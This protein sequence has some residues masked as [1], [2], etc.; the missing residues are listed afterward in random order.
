MKH[1]LLNTFLYACFAAIFG[2]GCAA[3]AAAETYPS[4][5][6]K[7]VVPYPPGGPYDTIARIVG[8]KLS[9][10]LGQPFIVENRAGANGAIGATAVAK[11]GPDGYTLLVGGIGPNA[12]NASLYPKLT[13]SPATDFVPVAHVLNSPN[14][15]VVNAAFKANTVTELLALARGAPAS[16][17]YASAGAGS[18]THLFAVMFE[19]AT[20]VKLL[21][22]TYKGDAP[23]VAATIGGVTSM[24]FA[25]AA[26][27]LP[28]IGSGR[29]RA[30]AVTGARRLPALSQV[31]TM[32]EAGVANYQAMAW[33]GFFAPKDTPAD[34]VAKLN[35]QINAALED[36]EVRAKFEQ[37]GSVEVVGGTADAFGALVTAEI[38]RWKTVIEKGG[39]T[40]D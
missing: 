40:V 16:L 33:Y 14:V 38:A 15:L 1:A 28:H 5:P 2:V 3:G 6:V 35:R 27:I 26:S 17:P 25:S 34:V 7:I 10:S 20:H 21:P 12:I 30:L 11:S 18:S 4:K 32:S 9:E 23:A 24:Y 22:V 19:Q 31:P 13:Y 39:V 36:P 8:G 29:V 37:G